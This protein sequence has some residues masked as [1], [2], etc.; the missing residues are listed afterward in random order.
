MRNSP[1]PPQITLGLV[2]R[3]RAGD[4][5][6]YD[7]LFALSAE[8]ALLF[9][10]LRLGSRLRGRLESMDV[11]QEA[12]VEA[13]RAFPDFE[14]RGDDSFSRWLCRLIENKIRGLAD[15]FDAV[16][17]RPPGEAAPISHVLERVRAETPGPSTAFELK[18]DEKR[19]AAALERL[20]EEERE[21]LLHRFFADRSIDDIA[22]LTSRSSS[23]VRRLLGRAT[24]R[25]GALLEEGEARR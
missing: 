12:Y 25:L 8:R 13:M 6:A 3:A 16:K 22:A 17:R 20:P 1:A 4:R 18:E 7:H 11:L 9:I 5:G 15:H 21:V 2:Q 23:S 10:R 19:L 14:F 24:A